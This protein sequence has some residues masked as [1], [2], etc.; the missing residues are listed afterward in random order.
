MAASLAAERP[1]DG[2]ILVT[3]FDS[4]WR[5]AAAQFPWLPVRLLFRNNLDPAEYLAGSR[6]PVAL[7]SAGGDGLVL[8]ARTE[9]LRHA[10]PHL[11]FDR[12]IPGTD[13]NNIYRSL[14]FTPAMRGCAAGRARG[15]ALK[16]FVSPL[17]HENK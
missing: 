9:A 11:V 5:V 3:A 6:L 12:T 1:L 4:L 13:H 14:A 2:L 10:I 16:A 7:I 17:F 15:S 8:P